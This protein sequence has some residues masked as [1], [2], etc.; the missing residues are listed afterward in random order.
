[1]Y[2]CRRVQRERRISQTVPRLYPE[3][4]APSILCRD[5]AKE[6]A[7]YEVTEI[8]RK[9]FIKDQFSEAYNPQQN[10]VEGMAIRYLKQASHTLMDRTWS[11]TTTMV[12]CNQVSLQYPQPYFQPSLPDNITPYQMRFG[13]T[14]DI[15]AYLQFTF[16]EPVLF[17]DTEQK[18]PKTQ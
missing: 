16:W 12:L 9:F 17:L 3:H 5:N 14:P 13:V 11:T 8:N 4:G 10:P 15:S 6:E 2:Q 1:M 7:S 18:W